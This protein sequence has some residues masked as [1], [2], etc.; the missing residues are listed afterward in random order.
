VSGATPYLKPYRK[1]KKHPY[2]SHYGRIMD[3]TNIFFP[4][5]KEIGG[6]A[7]RATLGGSLRERLAA[8]RKKPELKRIEK[9]MTE[10][11][12]TEN[13]I[14]TWIIESNVLG[15]GVEV[16]FNQ[17]KPDHVKVRNVAYTNDE[18]REL[19]STELNRDDIHNIHQVKQKFRGQVITADQAK[20][21]E[22][23]NI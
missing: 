17:N 5:R 12:H 9:P 8:A 11:T 2:L 16:V 4:H 1:I 22:E 19:I 7:T 10:N 3:N 13:R 18:I 20:N 21:K 6:H 14:L 15:G 23:N